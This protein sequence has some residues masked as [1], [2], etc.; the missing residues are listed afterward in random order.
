MSRQVRSSLPEEQHLYEVIL[1]RKLDK[2]NLRKK[3]HNQAEDVEET[4]VSSSRL[5]PWIAM[6][7]RLGLLHLRPIAAT[8]H[9][10]QSRTMRQP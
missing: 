6:T 1:D 9:G 10:S 4:L 5:E 3:V 2:R 8:P 7:A